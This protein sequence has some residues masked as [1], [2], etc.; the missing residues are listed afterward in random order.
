[1]NQR[2][3]MI[4]ADLQIIK[5]EKNLPRRSRT[6]VPGYVP[7]MSLPEFIEALGVPLSLPNNDL[8]T[9]LSYGQEFKPRV[10]RQAQSLLQTREFSRWLGDRFSDLLLVDG[11]MD[12]AANDSLSTMSLLCT[13]LIAS[14]ENSQT[15]AIVLHFFCG[16]HT[17]PSYEAS[18]PNGMLR[19]LLLQ[20]STALRTRRKLSL[21]FIQTEEEIAD[22]ESR[23][24]DSLCFVL[25]RL[26]MQ[27]PSGTTVFCLIDGISAF[28]KNYCNF[29][30]DLEYVARSLK[31]TTANEGLAAPFKVLLTSG[32]RSTVIARKNIV[33]RWQHVSLLDSGEAGGHDAITERS[34]GALLSRQVATQLP[35]DEEFDLEL[36]GD[37]W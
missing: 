36:V 37:D 33:E 18:G 7:A 16:L 34:V 28:E 32:C 20:L 9:V 30:T 31:R 14:I 19:A 27:V 22:V 13:A 29:R 8:R 3:E 10:Q 26:L 4:Q 6:P 5:R 35:A 17:S 25:N 12:S 21:E 23:R 24:L 15:D 1:M 2:E 11:N